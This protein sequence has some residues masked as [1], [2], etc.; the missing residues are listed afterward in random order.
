[1]ELHL[2]TIMVKDINTGSEGSLGFCNFAA[3]DDGTAY[4][5]ADDG[6]HG[7]ELWKTDGT[8]SRDTDGQGHPARK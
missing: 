7:E 3:L 6:I 1:M 5:L 2:G 4:F 8:E